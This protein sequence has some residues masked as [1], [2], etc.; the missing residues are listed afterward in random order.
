[1][2]GFTPKCFEFG[3]DLFLDFLEKNASNLKAE[4]YLPTIVNKMITSEK[5]SV[6]VLESDSKWFG[7]TYSNDKEK[8]QKE[9]NALKEKGV[10]PKK[11][12]S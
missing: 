7:V 9:I 8:V 3:E 10:Y 4:F 5:A 6:K 12:W 11:L 2:W 1:F